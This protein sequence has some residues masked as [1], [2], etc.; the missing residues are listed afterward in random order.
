M[1]DGYVYIACNY[2]GYEGHG[3]PLAVFSSHRE[4]CVFR[5]GGNAANGCSM[6][7]YKM[8]LDQLVDEAVEV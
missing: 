3:K 5:E 1:E 8:K 2:V 7:I 4:A 6:K